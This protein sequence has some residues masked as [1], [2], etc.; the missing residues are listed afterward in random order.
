MAGQFEMK[1]CGVVSAKNIEK[2]I[3]NNFYT[4][5]EANM[6]VFSMPMPPA[7]PEII[8]HLSNII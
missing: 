4:T 1:N 5:D 2:I 7:C 8:L 6:L 3:N